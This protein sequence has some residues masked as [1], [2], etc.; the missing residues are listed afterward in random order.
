[1]S[2]TIQHVQRGCPVTQ[3]GPARETLPE[4]PAAAARM[5]GDQ[6]PAAHHLEHRRPA[7][8]LRLARRAQ[9]GPDIVTCHFVR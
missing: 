8:L 2:L 4:R 7:F 9:R 6:E 5:G 1:M 3:R